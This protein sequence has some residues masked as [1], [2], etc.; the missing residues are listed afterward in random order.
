MEIKQED[1]INAITANIADVY[2]ADIEISEKINK[3]IEEKIDYIFASTIDSKINQ[4]VDDLIKDGF[5]REYT[6]VDTFG[7]AKGQPTTIR[8]EIELL[9]TDYWKQRVDKNGKRTESTYS[10][11]SRAEWLMVQ[12]T[13][14]DFTKQLKQEAVNITASLKDGIRK[15]FQINTNR[16]LDELFKVKSNGDKNEPKY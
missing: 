15:Q 1:L 2:L 10:S 9:L 4:I 6:K 14:E 16:M 8:K 11:Y 12:I 7:Q 5:N 13:A 3:Y